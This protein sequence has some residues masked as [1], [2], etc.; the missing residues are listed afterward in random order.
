MPDAQCCHRII[1]HFAEA[2][3]GLAAVLWGITWPEIDETIRM[4]STLIGIIYMSVNCLRGIRDLRRG[5]DR[6]DE[7]GAL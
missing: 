5:R 4:V 7:E 2:G 1:T 6:R 3:V